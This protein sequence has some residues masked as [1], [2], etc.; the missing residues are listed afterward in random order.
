MERQSTNYK[1]V[2]EL[3]HLNKV[4]FSKTA[5]GLKTQ[6]LGN[7]PINYFSMLFTEEFIEFI[8]F[9]VQETNLYA[10]EIFI[11]AVGNLSSQISQ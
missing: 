2:N 6:P 1:W 3:L 8:E 5:A 11:S 7:K 10:V 4:S 9:I